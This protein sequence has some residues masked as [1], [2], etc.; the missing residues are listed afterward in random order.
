[1]LS[2]RNAIWL[3]VLTAVLGVALTGAALILA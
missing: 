3:M 1:M 2:T